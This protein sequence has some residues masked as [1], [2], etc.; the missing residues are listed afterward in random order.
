MPS[1]RSGCVRFH[2]S[3][4]FPCAR[5]ASINCV[6]I[7][8]SPSNGRRR[9]ASC[10]FSFMV[11]SF[12]PC[13]PLPP[14]VVSAVSRQKINI[15]PVE[16]TRFLLRARHPRRK[17]EGLPPRHVLHLEQQDHFARVFHVDRKSTRLNSSHAN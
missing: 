5:P 12:P 11:F 8:P 14:G 4:Q 3:P 15:R 13:A 1:T 10:N 17:H 6:P 9:I 16:H 2:A 7:A